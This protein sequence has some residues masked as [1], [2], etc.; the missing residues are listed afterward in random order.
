MSTAKHTPG[1]W[2]HVGGS[3]RRQA[4][5]IRAVGDTVGV[6]AVAQV[7]ARGS[8][9]EQAANGRVLAAAPDMLRELRA[10]YRVLV[11]LP[12]FDS[13]VADIDAAIVKATGG[14]A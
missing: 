4:P 9:G 12:G 1:P 2:F 14:E 11:N 7:C 6:S 5:Y 8:A 3:D 13:L 10:A